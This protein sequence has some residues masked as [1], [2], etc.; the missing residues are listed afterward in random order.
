MHLLYVEDNEDTIDATMLYLDE[1]FDAIT[2]AKNGK[3][4]V[5]KFQ[6]HTIDMIISDINM[7]IMDGLEMAEQI[8]GVNPHIPII[9]FSAHNE[10]SFIQRANALNIE[11]Y[12]YKPL[13]HHQFIALLEEIMHKM[14]D[15]K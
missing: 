11:G 14:S 15:K 13:H 4:G 6:K 10:E 12:L 8:K 2:V 5:E 7:P 1:F 3:E 9:F